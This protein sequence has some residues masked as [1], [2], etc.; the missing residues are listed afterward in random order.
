MSAQ[1]NRFGQNRFGA[2]SLVLVFVIFIA[3][4]I[5]TN[6]L[7]RGLRVDFTENNIY[8]LSDGTKRILDDI[9]EP[10]NL[11][12]FWSDEATADARS[13]RDYATR[14][15]ELL[16]EFAAASDGK[17]KLEVIDPVP[18]SEEEDQA[19]QF[20]LHDAQM[21]QSPDPIYLGLAGTNSIG[22]EE[23]IPFF[24]P[25]EQETLE[26]DIAKLVSSLANPESTVVGVVSGVSMTG[27]F[28]P[29]TQQMSQPWVVYE[30]AR[31]MFE[32][33]DLGTSFESVPEDVGVL[34]IV[35]PKD[36]SPATQYAIDQFVMRGGRALIFVD[37]LASIDAAQEPGM[38]QGMPPVGQSSNL[39]ELF[40]GWGIEYAAQS[41][42]ADASLAL[43][44]SN[45]M[46]GRPV[47]H[48][49]YLGIGPGQLTEGDVVTAELGTMNLAMPGALAQ[50]V[51]GDAD[52]ENGENG[53]NE[54][55]SGEAGYTFEPLLRSSPDAAVL[56]ASRFTFLTDPAELQQGFAAGGESLVLAARITGTLPSA[57]PDGAPSEALPTTETA[58]DD[59]ADAVDDAESDAGA[60]SDGEV[61]DGAEADAESTGE[62][63]EDADEA[64][65][66]D[67]GAG[68]GAAAGHLAESAQ[69]ANVIIV[70]DVDILSDHLWVSVQ[71]FFGQQIATAFAANG[72]F[73][74][75]ALESL[76]GSPD[77]ISVRSRG[78]WSRPFTRV[79]E[80][81]ADA[82]ARFLETEQR[83]E[84]QLD[85]TERRLAELQSARD[86]TGSLLLT[87]EQEAEIDRFIEQRAE[88]RRELRAV[89]RGLDEDIDTLGTWLKVINILLIPLLLV[90]AAIVVLWRR[91][92]RAA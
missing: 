91:R 47:R 12:F 23:I 64:A 77:L 58:G 60:T 86:D 75:N 40:S 13:I 78:S 3:A 41:V 14:V 68:D 35:Q 76:S 28:D 37:P 34:W 43:Q 54:D 32:L 53:A 42:V 46:T 69:P 36:L 88:I 24:Q 27:G 82:E 67:T 17:L 39:P 87:D 26:Y 74:V 18:F 81:R 84:Q 66:G 11:Y 29:M 33:R 5:V 59:G 52:G 63:N 4:V 62:T 56:P 61:D 44:L 7:F 79:D 20:G 90:V 15:R 49:G 30:Q 65:G 89:Q 22:D 57:F 19:A 8:T 45:P 25:G 83:L 55:E 85:E 73:V 50:A 48:Y 6:L 72:A 10:I 2:S 51:T 31:Q 80:L 71:N 21:P 1:Q 9:D 70:A 92:R 38:P 16:E